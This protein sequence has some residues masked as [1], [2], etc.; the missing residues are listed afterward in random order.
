M[1]DLRRVTAL[2]GVACLADALRRIA[3]A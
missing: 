2:L 3:V 1:A